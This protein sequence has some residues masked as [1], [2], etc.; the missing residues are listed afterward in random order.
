MPIE[1]RARWAQLRVGLMAL[2]SIAILA[3]LVFLMTG[4]RGLFKGKAP[5]FVYFGDSAALAEGSPVRLN[6]I[7]IGS[8]T[9]VGLSG[10]SE[11]RRVVK[12]SLEVNDEYLSAIP[13]DSVAS[14]TAENVLAVKYINIT[15]GKSPETV[16][17]GAEL[18]SEDARE[19]SGLI[20]QA[21]PLMENMTSILKRMDELLTGVEGGKGNIGLLLKDETLYN[22]AVAIA[23]E[24]EKLIKAFNSPTSTLGKLTHEDKLYEDLRGTI[25]RVNVVMDG[26]EHGE[27]TAGKFLKDPAL[28]DQLL[29]T[30]TDVR[31]TLAD[32]EAGKGTVGKLLKSDELHDRL[33]ASMGKID[34]LLDNINNGKGTLGQLVVNPALYETLDGTMREVHGLMKDFRSNPKKFL[35]IKLAIF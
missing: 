24:G 16:K 32:I 26:L 9:K 15:K 21:Y 20:Q 7:Y 30:I 34:T 18:R 29:A 4:S 25:A 14:V 11:P 35:R 12:V 27:G 1:T 5:L 22:K 2:V 33:K 8:V 17:P 28:Y 19:F 6:G 3:F 10:G 13:V 23:D 31:K